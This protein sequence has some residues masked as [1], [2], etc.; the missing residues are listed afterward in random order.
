MDARP[1]SRGN[2]RGFP[3]IAFAVALLAPPALAQK[4]DRPDVR[5]GDRWQF[6]QYFGTRSPEPNRAWVITAVSAAG[7]EGTENG[8]PLVLTADLNPVESP[9]DSAA[10]LQFLRF[11]LEVGDRW[12]YGGNWIFKEKGSRGRQDGEVVV[13]AYEKVKVYAGEF[14]AYKLEAKGHNRGVSGI[15]SQIDSD[16]TV[17]YWYAPAARAIVKSI[18]WN[19]YLGTRNVELVSFDLRP[20]KE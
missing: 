18:A 13:A 6:V 3:A 15:G 1:H 19:P 9:R 4:A 5:L 8:E 12:T 16:F 20:V 17:T 11:P 7:L 10:N 2:G 14:D